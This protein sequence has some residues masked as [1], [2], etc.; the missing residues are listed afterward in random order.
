LSF[1]LFPKMKK[2]K[3]VKRISEIEGREE[4]EKK[5]E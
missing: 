2:R 4:E 3:T 5:R 1:F